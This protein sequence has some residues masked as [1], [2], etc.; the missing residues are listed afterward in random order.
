MRARLGYVVLRF[1]SKQVKG[2]MAPGMDSEAVET[3][4]VARRY[5]SGENSQLQVQSSERSKE[6]SEA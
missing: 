4:R 2:R 5:W 6:R 1:T 3:I